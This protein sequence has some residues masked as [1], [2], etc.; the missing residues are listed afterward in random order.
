MLLWP[1]PSFTYYRGRVSIKD[2]V[3]QYDAHEIEIVE[4]AI[5]FTVNSFF[6][7][8]MNEDELY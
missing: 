5:L 3:I 2:L 1:D 4:S 6:R 8:D 7:H